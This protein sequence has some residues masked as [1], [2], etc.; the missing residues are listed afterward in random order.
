MFLVEQ[1]AHSTL[2]L[3]HYGYLIQNGE[4]LSLPPARRAAGRHAR[5]GPGPRFSS[6][7]DPPAG[8]TGREPGGE[9]APLGPPAA[10]SSSPAKRG[11]WAGR[12][13]RGKGS[14]R[15]ERGLW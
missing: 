5:D 14:L 10:A 3:A 1:N 4:S 2:T 6:A 15:R 13:P 8:G 12:G 11:A 7:S 9:R